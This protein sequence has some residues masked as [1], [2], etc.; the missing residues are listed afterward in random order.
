MTRRELL[1]SQAI[2]FRESRLKD[3][4]VLAEEIMAD[5]VIVR[6]NALLDHLKIE[7]NDDEPD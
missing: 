2:A 5:F 6:M 4:S 7:N 1:I 3:A